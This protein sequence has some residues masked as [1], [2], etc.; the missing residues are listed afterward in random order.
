MI[1]SWTS[2]A[3]A[4]WTCGRAGHGPDDAHALP[5]P[6]WGDRAVLRAHTEAP[7]GPLWGLPDAGWLPLRCSGGLRR[8][9]PCRAGRDALVSGR[10]YPNRRT[11]PGP[12]VV[13]PPVCR[14]G[15]EDRSLGTRSRTRI[16]GRG[17]SQ[18][19]MVPSSARITTAPQT[20]MPRRRIWAST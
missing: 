18:R 5:G 14:R 11:G 9:V 8:L 4:R 7:K 3:R 17:E 13:I 19:M 12:A 6:G 2:Q 20:G 10:L 16:H 15:P 1:V